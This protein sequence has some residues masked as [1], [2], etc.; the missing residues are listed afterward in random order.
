MTDGL[1]VIDT[2]VWV[3]ALRPK[4]DE[5]T[6]QT[7]SGVLD[8]DRA[9][10]CGVI[11]MELLSGARNRREYQELLQSLEALHYLRTPEVTWRKVAELSL[12]LRA[13]GVSIPYADLL[14][15][16]IAMDNGCGLLHSNR[17]FDLIASFTDLRVESGLK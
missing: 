8:E 10:T 1:V 3:L 5:K 17:H 7:V 11:M 14:I 12:N 4:V 9:A 15:A 6:K 16:Q 13:K 2:S